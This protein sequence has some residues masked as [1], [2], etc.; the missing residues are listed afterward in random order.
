[1]RPQPGCGMI[2]QPGRR[3][4]CGAAGK[5]RSR[6]ARCPAPATA[7]RCASA[8]RRCRTCRP[9]TPITPVPAPAADDRAG[10][11]LGCRALRAAARQSGPRRGSGQLPRLAARTAPGPHRLR[12]APVRTRSARF[13]PLP[14]G[15]RL[16]S[17]PARRMP[18]SD[19]H[20]RHLLLGLRQ[21]RRTARGPVPGVQPI[22][23]RTRRHKSSAGHGKVSADRLRG[24]CR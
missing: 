19:H 24:G 5:S 10:R 23:P 6:S 13:R 15:H 21:R 7:S 12:P 3:A 22:P 16:H 8:S 14:P 17:S 11:R 18:G 1:V 4:T 9:W 20:R 2:C